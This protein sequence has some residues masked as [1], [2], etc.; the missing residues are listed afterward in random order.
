MAH[1][2]KRISEALVS[3]FTVG[4]KRVGT[5][6]ATIGV[7]KQGNNRYHKYIHT[8]LKRI[9]EALVSLM[10]LSAG[11]SKTGKVYGKSVKHRFAVGSQNRL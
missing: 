4:Q 1:N 11:R 8:N 10:L 5:P 7:S 9:S 3:L 2:L 6:E